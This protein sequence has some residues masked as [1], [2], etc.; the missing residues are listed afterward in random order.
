MAIGGASFVV[1]RTRDS[2]SPNDGAFEAETQTGSGCSGSPPDAGVCCIDPKLMV[3]IPCF[4]AFCEA[5]CSTCIGTC[6]LAEVCCARNATHIV[7]RSMDAGC[8]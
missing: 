5:G 3:D 2:G 6:G 8:P 1:S 7:C 4:G